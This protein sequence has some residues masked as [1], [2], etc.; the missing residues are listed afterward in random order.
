MAWLGG[1]AKHRRDG[2][3]MRDGF[4][5]VGTERRLDGVVEAMARFL[6]SLEKKCG[7]EGIFT[8]I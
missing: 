4:L 1:D 7:R 5:R 6:G 8:E 2:G 3:E